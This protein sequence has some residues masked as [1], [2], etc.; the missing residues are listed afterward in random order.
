LRI[1][2][3]ATY[4]L[5]RDLSGVGVYSSEIISGLTSG[6]PEIDWRLLYR[7]HRFGLALRE[8]A[9][10]TAHRGVLFDRSP[11]RLTKLFH[12]LNQRLPRDGFE[13][14]VVT[15]HDL[16]V[17]TAEYSS[18]DFRARFADQARR[19]ANQADHVIAVS[20]FTANQIVELLGVEEARISVIAHGVRVLPRCEGPRENV[21]LHVGAVQKRKN[22]VRLVRAFDRR[23]PND[24]RL[25]LAG[26]AGYGSEE[27]YQAV[28]DARGRERITLT[29]YLQDSELFSWYARA[30]IF[31]FPS[32][33][34]GFG[35][36]VLEA[37]AAGIPVVTSLASSLPEVAGDAALLVNPESE[38][39]LGD[40]LVRLISDEAL[41]QSLT[42]AGRSR[43]ALFPWE[44]A[45][46]ATFRVYQSVW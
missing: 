41:R 23:V 38:E 12:G 11:W 45:V 44:N 26:S 34:E 39:E 28:R 10:P 6:H 21:I 27:V 37:M 17:L 7:P 33:G 8:A 9:L 43:A 46:A 18:P 3:D 29:G 15:F 14:Q 24:W 5:G 40:A 19:A 31:A 32:L 13:R 16:F 4:S 2:L 20:R 36:P 1:A 42:I 30:R 35:I 25:V 22:L